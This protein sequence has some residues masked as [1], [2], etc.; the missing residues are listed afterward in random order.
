M[1]NG[2]ECGNHV[3]LFETASLCILKSNLV[4]LTEIA[5][6]SYSFSRFPFFSLIRERSEGEKMLSVRPG[7]MERSC[8]CYGK[9]LL[10]VFLLERLMV[11]M[12]TLRR[13]KGY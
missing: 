8:E 5:S 13:L 10:A 7:E 2:G 1:L 12:I 9:A 3:L 6:S 4:V 11:W